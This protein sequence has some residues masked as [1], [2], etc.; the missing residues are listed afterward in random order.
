MTYFETLPLDI[1]DI[2][3][4]SRHASGLLVWPPRYI[5]I[6][7]SGGTDSRAWLSTDRRSQ[8]SVHRLIEKDGTLYKILPDEK[9]CWGAGYGSVGATV[10]LNPFALQIE[11]ENLNDGRDPYPDV[12][13]LSCARQVAEWWGLYGALPVLSHAQVDRR[14]DDPR[15]FPWPHFYAELFRL[16]AAYAGAQA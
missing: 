9:Q 5:I 14:K 16:V 11:L 3:A 8:V 6:H 10:N 2:P 12:Q 1:I 15:G 13:V 4:D 7:A